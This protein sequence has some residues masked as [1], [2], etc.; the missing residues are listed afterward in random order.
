MVEG[1]GIIG[2]RGIRRGARKDLLGELLHVGV[3]VLLALGLA[4]VDGDRLGL[5]GRRGRR[6]RRLGATLGGLG[7]LLLGGLGLGTSVLGNGSGHCRL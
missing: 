7:L 1:R 2:P 5:W 6:G 4:G 3:L